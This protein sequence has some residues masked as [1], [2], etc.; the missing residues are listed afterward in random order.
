MDEKSTDF[1]I[2]FAT[3]ILLGAVLAVIAQTLGWLM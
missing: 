3:M 1:V 2:V